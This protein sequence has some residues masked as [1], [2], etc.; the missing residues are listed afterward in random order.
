MSTVVVAAFLVAFS[1]L[2]ATLFPESSPVEVMPDFTMVIVLVWS[3]VRGAPEG[4]V[5]AFSLGMLLDVLALDPLGSNGLALLPAVVLGALGGQ[6]FFH[7]GLIVPILATLVATFLH[8]VLL[9]LVRSSGGESL[10]FSAVG[11]L[12]ALQ[13][14]LNMIV[15]PPIYLI[16][17]FAQRPPAMRHA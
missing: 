13:S 4:L 12:V 1:F 7:S 14:L 6:R 11:R 15:V 8:A 10:A 9:L 16:A 17:S 3:A 2:Q 5:W